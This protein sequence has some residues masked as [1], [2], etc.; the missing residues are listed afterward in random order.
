MKSLTANLKQVERYEKLSPN[1][2]VVFGNKGAP[3]YMEAPMFD[4]LRWP[5]AQSA[6]QA[7]DYKARTTFIKDRLNKSSIA[8]S[9]L[10]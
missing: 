2:D 8:F 6:V 7:A 3:R 9:W 4:L 10:A 5:G 1:E